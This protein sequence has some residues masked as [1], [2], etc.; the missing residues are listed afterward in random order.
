[1]KTITNILTAIVLILLAS[2]SLMAQGTQITNTTLA[3]AMTVNGAT[4]VV[5]A[6][7]SWLPG[8]IVIVEHEAMM[9]A[10][11]YTTGNTIPLSQRGYTGTLQ[12]AH[13]SG[14]V[15]MRALAA[16]VRYSDL[17][18]SCTAA[19]QPV[20]PVV[21]INRTLRDVTLYNCNNGVWVKQF[22]PNDYPPTTTAYCTPNYLG[23]L[24]LLTSFGDATSPFTVG[25]N[26]TPVSGTVFY[27][28]IDIPRTF[29]ATTL[30]I[31]NGLVAGTDLLL[32]GI[33][34]ADGVLLTNT[35]IA[36][37]TAAGVGRFQK[38]TMATPFLLT[39]PA[40]YWISLQTNG[41]TT[42]FRTVPLT[43]GLGTAGLGS[44]I[45][46][47]GSSARGTFATLPNLTAFTDA[48]DGLP[49]TTTLPTTLVNNTSPVS[50]VE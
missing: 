11:T 18:G 35:A 2:M 40:R 6:A 47:L 41:T 46:N 24:A 30:E 22:L 39:G 48:T 9:V 50:C 16:N 15:V 43:P 3:S 49:L 23:A 42:R 25:T 37:T 29:Q 32:M 21:S 5:T 17:F 12:T 44:F 45:G 26:Q 1:M 10:S 19:N 34:R 7:T 28:T 4:M 8:D 31:L 20:L 36:G 14:S 38:M 27:G 33:Y 13:P